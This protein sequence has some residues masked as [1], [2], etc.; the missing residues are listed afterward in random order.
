MILELPE[1]VARMVQKETRAN[2]DCQDLQGKWELLVPSVV[3]VRREGKAPRVKRELLAIPAWL[4]RQDLREV[5]EQQAPKDTG[6][7]RETLGDLVYLDL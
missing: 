7:A 5:W 3:R 2:L 6:E 1:I 4:V